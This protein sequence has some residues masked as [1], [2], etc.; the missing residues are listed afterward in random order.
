MQWWYYGSLMK[1]KGGIKA[2]S[3]R[4]EIGTSW[5][6]GRWNRAIKQY[7]IGERFNRG[8]SYARKG[9]VGSIK[10]QKGQVTATVYGSYE[11][12]VTIDVRTFDSNTWAKVMEPIFSR[13]AIISKLLAGRMPDDIEAVFAEFGLDLFPN[14]KD[15][16]TD[17]TCMDWVNPCKHIVAI[18]LLLAEEFDRNPFLIFDMRGATRAEI[19]HS[20]G[21]GDPKKRAKVAKKPRRKKSSRKLDPSDPEAFWGVHGPGTGQGEAAVPEVDAVLV[22]QLGGFPF[23]R[24]GES[25]IPTMEKTYHNASKVGLRAFLGESPL[26]DEDDAGD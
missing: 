13:P 9:R 5:W 16:K 10:I 1:V 22:K 17:C 26:G 24:G 21:I 11:Y 4:G 19:L 8:K 6:A 7:D 2:Q 25:F 18:Y 23:W 12:D 3:K 14:Q 15:I 20:I